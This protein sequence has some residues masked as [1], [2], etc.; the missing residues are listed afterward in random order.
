MPSF[1]LDEMPH[2]PRTVRL[3]TLITLRWFAVI[4]QAVT[5]FIVYYWLE[6]DLPIAACLS[7]I[8]VSAWLNV[9]LRMHYGNVQRLEP[10]RVAW[11]L[12]YDIAQLTVLMVLTGGLENPFAFFVLAPVSIAAISLPLRYTLPLGIFALA[13]STF[14]AF[15]YWPLPW[16]ATETLVQPPL[17]IFATWV[18]NLGGIVFIGAYAWQVAEE[19]RLMA[20]AL[21]ATELVLAREQHLSQLDGLAAA[22]AHELGTPLST[23]SV[24]AKELERALA[25]DSPHADDIK[26]LR[27]QAARCRDI[28]AKLTE[29]SSSGAP[30]DHAPLTVLIEEV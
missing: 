12:A 20:D 5:V 14:I 7:V 2:A 4:G 9:A 27:E 18:A 29:L 11:L 8:V 6:F 30:F 16:S 28:L 21:T 26:L 25:P 3:K 15:F 10:D 19:G 1:A 22:A 13:T 24:V 23:I 17:Y